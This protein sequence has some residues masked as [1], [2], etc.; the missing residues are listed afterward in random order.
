MG[1]ERPRP[2]DPDLSSMVPQQLG[3]GVVVFDAHL[4]QGKVTKVAIDMPADASLLASQGEVGFQGV[5]VSVGVGQDRAVA[6]VARPPLLLEGALKVEEHILHAVGPADQRAWGD[7]HAAHVGGTPPTG[8]VEGLLVRGGGVQGG[9][10]HLRTL[11]AEGVQAFGDQ[12]VK[13]GCMRV[14]IATNAGIE[15]KVGHR[16]A[17]CVVV[18][19]KVGVEHAGGDAFGMEAQAWLGCGPYP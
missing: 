1:A 6:G 16:H 10:A 7:G 13:V 12:R 17:L 4:V 14:P 2:G 19:V 11:K 5:H 15:G 3:D 9:L 8:I 18:G